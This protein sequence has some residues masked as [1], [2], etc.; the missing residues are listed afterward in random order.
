MNYIKWLFSIW[1]GHL[2]CGTVETDS[3][4]ALWKIVILH[5]S[6]RMVRYPLVEM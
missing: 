2:E 3:A 4:A 6:K 1:G 5:H